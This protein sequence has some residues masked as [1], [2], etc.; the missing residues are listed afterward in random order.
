VLDGH[1]HMKFPLC[2][3]LREVNYAIYRKSYEM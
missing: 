3:V 2:R 1:F